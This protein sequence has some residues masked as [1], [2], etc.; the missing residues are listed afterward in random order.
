MPCVIYFMIV[1]YPT[2]DLGFYIM[3][4]NSIYIHGW[5]ESQ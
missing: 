2:I 5:K 3:V 1:A 4:I